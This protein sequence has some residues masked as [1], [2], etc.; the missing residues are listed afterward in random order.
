VN[1]TSTTCT[2]GTSSTTVN[3]NEL[4]VFLCENWNSAQ[5]YGVAPSGYSANRTA[6]SRNTTGWWDKSITATGVQATSTTIVSD[7]SVG[8]ILTFQLNAG[9]AAAAP[10]GKAVI[11]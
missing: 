9:G 2:S 8:T 10:R 3:P 5:T 4:V 7:V 6:S 11:F 1:A